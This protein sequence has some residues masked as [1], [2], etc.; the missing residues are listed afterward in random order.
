MFCHDSVH[1]C[2]LSIMS[3]VSNRHTV[4]GWGWGGLWWDRET[5]WQVSLFISSLKSFYGANTS[6]TGDRFLDLCLVPKWKHESTYLLF[7]IIN[8]IKMYSETRNLGIANG[9]ETINISSARKHLIFELDS[10]SFTIVKI[11]ADFSHFILT[12]NFVLLSMLKNFRLLC[13]FRIFFSLHVSPW[14]LTQ[15]ARPALIFFPYL[16]QSL[17]KTGKNQ[18]Q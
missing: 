1:F 11:I 17:L 16:T 6:L 10:S 14:A 15:P 12:L 18:Q 9:N 8:E 4:S 2:L 5:T 7:E 3:V 13:I